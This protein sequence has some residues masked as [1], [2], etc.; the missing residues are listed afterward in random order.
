MG[1]DQ[2]GYL[3][4][5]PVKIAAGRIK[6]AVR[7]CKRLRKQLLSAAD[8]GRDDDVDP[9]DIPEDPEQNIRTF[10]DWWHCI[11]TRDAC[12]R[13]DPDDPRQQLVYAGEM[14]WGDE[15]TGDGYQKLKEAFAWGYAEALGVR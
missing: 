9:A 8:E 13:L 2:V 5:G 7:A 6:L 10:V 15:P 11:D 3:V 14:S 1:A 4:R 12:C